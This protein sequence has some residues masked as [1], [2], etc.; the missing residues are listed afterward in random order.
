[1]YSYVTYLS[2]CNNEAWLMADLI[3]FRDTSN[4]IVQDNIDLPNTVCVSNAV[5]RHTGS[6]QVT[7]CFREL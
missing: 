7:V 1:M 6:I 2:L 4:Y 5:R 3:V